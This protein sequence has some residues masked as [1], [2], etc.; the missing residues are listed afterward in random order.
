MHRTI[1]L[2]LMAGG[3]LAGLAAPARADGTE[4]V[5]VIPGRPGVPVMFWGRDISGAVL[6]GDWGLAR[7]GIVTPTVVQEGWV[8]PIYGPAAPYYPTM[9]HRPRSGRLEVIPPANR[10]RPRPAQTYY[11][12]WMSQPDTSPVTILPPYD[13]PPVIVAPRIGNRYRPGPVTPV[14][15]QPPIPY[16]P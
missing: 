4:P 10:R 6:E 1:V 11:R 14:P 7:P 13:P 2:A 9:R 3:L 12:D 5:I 15:V 16:L 8:S